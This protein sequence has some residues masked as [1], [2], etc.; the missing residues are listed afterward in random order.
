MVVVKYLATALVAAAL[1]SPSLASAEGSLWRTER[2]W[3]KT[4][5]KSWGPH[6][7]V[8]PKKTGRVPKKQYR[9]TKDR[10]QTV[11]GKQVLFGKGACRLATGLPNLQESMKT[12][13]MRCLSGS[14]TSTSVSGRIKKKHTR[15]A[16][17]ITHRFE[18]EWRLNESHCHTVDRWHWKLSPMDP[19][20]AVSQTNEKTPTNKCE[21]PGKLHRLVAGSPRKVRAAIGETITFKVVAKDKAGCITKDTIRW[22]SKY[23]SITRSGKLATVGLKPR[24]F[25]VV[26]TARRKRVRFS[27]ELSE[28]TGRHPLAPLMTASVTPT[29][30]GSSAQSQRLGASIEFKSKAREE[31]DSAGPLVAG[32]I[33]V[34]AGLGL[35]SFG[36]LRRRRSRNG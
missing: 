17:Q 18:Y 30:S 31:N 10:I 6:C 25:E 4:E 29:G 32:G 12:N 15:E 3:R 34:T 35:V 33:L 20:P 11:D 27:V 8:K 7:G 5:V 13:M 22:R 1:Y 14:A 16:V 21:R 19:I 2:A 9:L 26:A 28:P 24:T 36:L 23:G